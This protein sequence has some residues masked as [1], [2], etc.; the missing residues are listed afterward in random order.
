MPRDVHSGFHIEKQQGRRCV[1]NQMGFMAQT[2]RDPAMGLGER[3]IQGRKI[4]RCN[5]KIQRAPVCFDFSGRVKF[6]VH[7]YLY[8]VGQL[9]VR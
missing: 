6:S 3:H 2:E 8:T 4:A 5:D 1:R 9:D 7:P